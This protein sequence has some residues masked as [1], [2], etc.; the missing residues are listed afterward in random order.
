MS[1]GERKRVG[2][3]ELLRDL[4]ISDTSYKKGKQD[5]RAETLRVLRKEYNLC[6]SSGTK[7]LKYFYDDHYRVIIRIA[8]ELGISEKE[9]E[10]KE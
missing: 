2:S 7:M 8:K 4:F 3:A 5:Q 10:E 1:E 6:L 9:L